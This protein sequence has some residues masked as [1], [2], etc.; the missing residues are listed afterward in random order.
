MRANVEIP[1]CSSAVMP[2]ASTQRGRM[3]RQILHAGERDR[4]APRA[5]TCA[6]PPEGDP[7]PE[8]RFHPHPGPQP[9][10][11]PPREQRN[12]PGAHCHMRNL[13][14][15]LDSA[16]AVSDDPAVAHR[17]KLPAIDRPEGYR[18]QGA[19]SGAAA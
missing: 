7:T 17:L 5:G 15:E 3:D 1:F 4:L 13:K 6:M 9:R 19:E 18:R 2:Y 11:P 14:H 8:Q 12:R 16:A 10:C